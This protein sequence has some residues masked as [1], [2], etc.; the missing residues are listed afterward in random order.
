M[1]L[2]G[3]GY[4]VDDPQVG[5]FS[6]IKFFLFHSQETIQQK[7]VAWLL[8]GLLWWYLKNVWHKRV[9]F[10]LFC[11]ASECEKI[12]PNC[13]LKPP[14][15]W[16][17]SLLLLF[18]GLFW[19]NFVLNKYVNSKPISRLS[20]SLRSTKVFMQYVQSQTLSHL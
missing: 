10:F 5:C 11:R 3:R 9:C 6:V 7:P 12:I 17:F 14:C 20:H 15:H 19:V 13:G 16:R 8:M 2:K 18:R 1:P 4:N